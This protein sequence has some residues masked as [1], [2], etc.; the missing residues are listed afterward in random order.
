MALARSLD[1]LFQ[2]GTQPRRRRASAALGPLR[3]WPSGRAAMAM[4]AGVA[5][6]FAGLAVFRVWSA[7]HAIAPRAQPADLITLVHAQADEPGSLGWKIKHDQRINIL[8]LGY[9]GPGH[10]GA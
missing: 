8:L 3:V 9:G 6:L 7:I 4:I 10:D 1:W 2:L 5:L